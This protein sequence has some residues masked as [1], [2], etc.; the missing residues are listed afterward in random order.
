MRPHSVTHHDKPKPRKA[1]KYQAPSPAATQRQNGGNITVNVVLPGAVQH[2][3]RK[4][5]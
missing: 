5:R 4:D 3:T 2:I 1:G